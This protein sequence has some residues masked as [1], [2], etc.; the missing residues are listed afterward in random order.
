MPNGWIIYVRL[1]FGLLSRPYLPPD[2]RCCRRWRR[3]GDAQIAIIEAQRAVAGVARRALQGGNHLVEHGATLHGVGMTQ[4]RQ[5]TGIRQIEV[6]GFEGATR[7]LEQKRYFTG[8][9]RVTP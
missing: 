5:A 1:A 3:G 2:W 9:Q 6:Q 7:A 4:Q 8:G